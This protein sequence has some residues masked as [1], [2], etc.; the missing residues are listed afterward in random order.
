MRRALLTFS[1]IFLL[2]QFWQS[3]AVRSDV[4]L[5]MG[6][7]QL[8]PGLASDS[9]VCTFCHTPQNG[10]AGWP[11][12]VSK[13]D[14]AEFEAFDTIPRIG[15]APKL[16]DASLVCLSCHDG[17]QAPDTSIN[18]PIARLTA[19]IPKVRRPGTRDH[20]VGV[21]YSGYRV[22]DQSAEAENTRLR[23]AVIDGQV[24]WWIDAE[25]IP[26]GVRDKTD[27]VFYTRES[28]GSSSPYIECASC[29]DP[30]GSRGDMFLRVSSSES[31]LCRTCH[32]I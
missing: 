31:N 14:P 17:T 4:D 13:R 30:H 3:L 5:S 18:S 26:N 6:P 27:V 15:G 25:P 1:S 19:Q 28:G 16:G 9:A 21:P 8:Q 24:R 12:W 23:S 20:P 11:L 22:D 2:A 7:H 29:H 32:N 10:S